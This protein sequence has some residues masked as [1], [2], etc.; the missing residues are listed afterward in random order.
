MGSSWRAPSGPTLLL[1]I[2]IKRTGKSLMLDLHPAGT[3]TWGMHCECA[4]APSECRSF[5]MHCGLLSQ[6]QLRA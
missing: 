6:G 1:I 3:A 4:P 2:S 5:K